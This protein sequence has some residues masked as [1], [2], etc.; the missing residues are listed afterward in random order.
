MHVRT[1][2]GFTLIELLI[3][4][5]LIGILAALSA[6]YLV[7]AKSS[8]N[9]S[10]A[11]SSLKAV[12]SGQ[13]T[14]ATVC[15]NGAFTL[16]LATLVAER[17]ASPDVDVS[18][19]SGFTFLLRAGLGSIPSAADCAGDPTQTAY[20][21]T[22]EPL[23]QSTGRRAFATTQAGTVWQDTSGVAPAEPFLAA[24]TVSTLQAE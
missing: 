14:F 4:V 24:G 18:P 7:A 3:V 11:V 19:K 13:A 15:G 20:Y 8:A 16:Q 1:A 10:S 2:K 5:A 22:A 9:E 23:A 21:L 17:F 12:N 6:P